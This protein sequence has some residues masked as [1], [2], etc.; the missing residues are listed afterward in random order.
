ME[1]QVS[2]MKRDLGHKEKKIIEKYNENILQ[3]E[4][5]I[6]ELKRELTIKDKK[7]SENTIQTESQILELKREFSLKEKKLIEKFTEE[8]SSFT[9]E[10]KELKRELSKKESEL[11]L[12]SS[13]QVSLKE[14]LA[15]QKLRNNEQREEINKLK[16]KTTDKELN[17]LKLMFNEHKEELAL[18]KSKYGDLREELILYKSQCANYKEENTELKS[19]YSDSLRLRETFIKLQEVL[20]EIFLRYSNSHEEWQQEKWKDS[21]EDEMEEVVNEVE[22]LKFMISKMANDNNWLVDRLAELGQENQRLKDQS[23][24][25]NDMINELKATSNAFKGFEN[26]RSKLL[27]HFNDSKR[28]GSLNY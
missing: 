22:F 19:L 5:Q 12:N 26:A 7:L 21:H 23:P 4:T 18:A 8:T 6:I 24:K 15:S 2:E 17:Q 16:A 27:H 25:K 14:E 28:D 1:A 9:S 3:L 11:E 20:H 10:I 13:K